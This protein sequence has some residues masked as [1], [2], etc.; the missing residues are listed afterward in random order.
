MTIGRKITAGFATVLLLFSA[1]TIG[2]Y[3]ALGRAGKK[4]TQYSQSA[5]ETNVA[6]A[7]ETSMLQV[8]MHVNEFLLSGSES[9]AQAY[10][11][12]KA[13][14]DQHLKSAQQAIAD[15][16]R[17]NEL[18]SA[19]RLFDDYDAA[20]RQIVENRK[21]CS[22]LQKNAL[23]PMSAAIADSLQKLLAGARNTGDMNASFQI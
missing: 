16:E 23:E 12:S 21:L 7:F 4:F 22:D 17:A 11:E 6:A 20:F 15:V 9:A 5:S 2:T 14:A 19:R 10:A 8:R 3:V 13:E 18:T 1:V